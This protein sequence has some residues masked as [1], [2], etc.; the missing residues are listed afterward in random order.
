MLLEADLWELR[1]ERGISQA[2]A[3]FLCF[4]STCYSN[5]FLQLLVTAQFTV[6]D[7]QPCH[8]R[9]VLHQISQAKQ[10]RPAP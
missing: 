10:V 6:P 5:V 7:T 8:L 2:Q 1:E 9:L 4:W 3:L